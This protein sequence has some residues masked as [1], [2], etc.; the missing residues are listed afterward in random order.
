MSP[1]L[2]ARRTVAPAS[3]RMFDT[4][5]R[6][7]LGVCS[8]A[9]FMVILDL[10]IVN[11]ALPSIQVSLSFS[12]INL[13]WVV[14][15][16]T[17]AFAGFL[18]LGGR[19]TDL[20]GLR[21]A[22]PISLIGFGAASLLGGVAPDQA[23][24]I[25]ARALQGLAGALMAA[26]SLATITA[27]FEAGPQRHRA[28]GLWG[29]M[30]GAGGAA[31]ALFGGVITQELGWRWVLLINPPIGITAAIIG[32]IVIAD[33]PTSGP[34]PSIDLPGALTLTGG[35]VALVYGIVNAG[36]VGWR[37]SLVIVPVAIGVVLLGIFPLV[38]A[39]LTRS[40]LVPPG[41]LR[42]ALR[43]A[44]AV[45]M[46]F[47]AALFP[48][49]YV[50]SLYL[51]QVLGRSPIET[52]LCFV[53]MTVVIFVVASR[54]G[55]LVG[56]FGVRAVLCS[57][58]AMMCVGLL[59][60]ARIGSSG[61]PIGF[62]V[63]PGVLVAIGIACSVV[64]STIAATQSATPAQ[65]GLASALV[66]TSRQV[67]GAIGIA[68]L[69]SLATSETSHLIGTNRSVADALTDGFRL[70]YLIAA[71]LVAVAFVVA[72]AFI[73]RNA[74]APTR[75][76]WQ[77]PA[78]ALGL[79]VAFVAVDLG[80]AGAPGS[81]IGSYTL[82]GAASYVSAPDLHPPVLRNIT[83]AGAPAPLSDD[84]A[85]ANFYDLT[86]GPM[87]GQSGPLLVNAALQPIWFHPVPT[88]VL[89][90]NL[91]EQ[92]YDGQPVLAWWQG[93]ITSTGATVSGEDIVV[94]DHYQTIATLHGR[95][96]WV[97]T[98]HDLVISGDD[99]WVTANKNVPID[100]TRYG[101]A[102]NGA[103][104]DSAVQEYDLRTGA[105]LYTWDALD[106]IPLSDSHTPPPTNGFPWDAYHVN[107]IALTGTS[108]FLV[109][110]RDTWAA[111]DVERST[112]KVLWSIGGLHSTY[113]FGPGAEFEWQH[114][115]E[116]SGDTVS[117]FDDHCCEITGA[118][119]YLAATGPSRAIVLHLNPATHEATLVRQITMGGSFDSVYMGNTEILPDKGVVV[120][121][122]EQPYLS[123]YNA[124]G[125]LVLEGRFLSPDL[126]YRATAVAHWVGRPLT[127]PAAALRSTRGRTAL[128]VSWNGETGV[129]RWRVLAG[130]SATALA[131]TTTVAR[132]GFETTIAVPTA[133]DYRV[134]ALS[135]SGAVLGTT[136]LIR[137]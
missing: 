137:H 75:A 94:N 108:S 26:A 130:S 43:R 71:G 33:R 22:L 15:A 14:D 88:D 92:T 10:T 115:V 98:L 132:S 8:V 116:V 1:L 117:V 73:G 60:L 28:I 20:L 136:A 113:R 17:I 40:P 42:G 11:V 24:L 91:S 82:A 77:M 85:L 111:Y 25:G 87:V 135:T 67:G 96:G 70:A 13:Q 34:R 5:Q 7:L 9:Q 118:G 78:V 2:A 56:R 124:A 99:A 66:N 114:D 48:M 39:H 122:G 127:S 123:E 109:S 104:V 103:L 30:N 46:C 38:E 18:M 16:Y 59:L 80:V 97:I 110:F 81:P 68:L 119:T 93:S 84:L 41:V 129:A 74:E 76:V 54:T 35:L 83:P 44:N 27:T 31:G 72:V 47:S 50:S 128:Y 106:H 32:A 4:R 125:A 126:S 63:L 133:A 53:P 37:S 79:I 65:S 120:G 69:I 23:L 107:S 64:P 29:A 100:L 61:S 121:W 51:Q 102:H 86:S 45:V 49:W 21:R 95:G 36:V 62:I 101:G 6:W 105:L 112:G 19:A 90:A 55:G 131:S 57:G 12:A 52:G 3:E 134:E 89:A 58:L